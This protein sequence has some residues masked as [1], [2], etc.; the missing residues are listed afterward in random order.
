VID[1]SLLAAGPATTKMLA[2]YG[3]E[4]IIV[5]SEASIAASGGS[6]QQGPPGMS[7]IN[8]AWFHNKYNPNKLSAT[9]DLSTAEG[10]DVMKRL[11][12]RSD[13]FV[14][15]RRPSVL[16]NLELSY[17]ELS[18]V[19]PD[20]IYLTMPTMGAGGPRSFYGGVSWGIQA[21][22]GLNMIS[23][24]ADRPPASPSPYSHPDVSCNPLHAVVAI[25]A[26]VRHRRR[27]GRGQFIELA[28][29]ES[30]ICWTGPALLQYTVNGALMERTENRH[31]NA[32]P[33]DVYRCEGDDKWAAICVFSD[34][35][36]RALCTTIGRPELGD[37]SAYA[38]LSARKAHE[39]ELRGIIEPW[40]STRAAE[41]VTRQLQAAG[42]PCGPVN[43][44]EQL[45]RQDPQLAERQLWT[46]VE[47]PELGTAIVERW[48]F[49]LSKVP[50]APP[51]R[52][53]LLGEHNDYVFQEVVE[54]SED[55]VNMYL[56]A[57]VFR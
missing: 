5:E 15:N 37:D 21:M 6:R 22:A 47:H 10:R 36:W 56:V 30:S 25:M 32:A 16:K 39:G 7:P 11:V 12:S 42:V 27:T 28:Q 1:F 26:A 57:D 34:E 55:E 31:P 50:P 23:N 52:A 54:L 35:Q 45:L 3:A 24:W 40:T 20:L 8:T 51:Q 43:N 14:A 2:D 29:Y 33:H 9:L 49:R 46:E 44:F 41:E 48:G 19:K 13:I 18:A 17:E 38:T 53:P 4:V